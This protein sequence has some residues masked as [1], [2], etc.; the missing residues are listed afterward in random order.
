MDVWGDRVSQKPTLV[1]AAIGLRPKEAAGSLGISVA[2]LNRLTE[3]GEI[4]CIKLA[5]AKIYYRCELERWAERR[6]AGD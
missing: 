1:N 3:A 2:T 6:T 5:R 4:R